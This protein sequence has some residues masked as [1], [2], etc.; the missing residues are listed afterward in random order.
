MI[1]RGKTKKRSRDR[2]AS[3]VS[4]SC[5]SNAT[6]RPPGSRCATV[7]HPVRFRSPVRALPGHGFGCLRVSA[8]ARARTRS[9]RSRSRERDAYHFGRAR[10]YPVQAAR[11]P[12]KGRLSKR[13]RGGWGR[14]CP[15]RHAFHSRWLTNTKHCIVSIDCDC[16]YL[17]QCTNVLCSS[18][19]T[20]KSL[21][22]YEKMKLFSPKRSRQR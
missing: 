1:G 4:A 3:N 8:Y 17:L 16:L 15:D 7:P 13:A 5:P 19:S 10:T 12:L 11:R 2:T 18:H 22:R 14:G 21:N 6:L 20:Y 9:G